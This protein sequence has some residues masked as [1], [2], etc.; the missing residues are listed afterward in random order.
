MRSKIMKHLKPEQD[1]LVQSRDF[2]TEKAESET[3]ELKCLAQL[4][5]KKE[6]QLPTRELF[7]K[8]TN[9]LS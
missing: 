8:V 5:T 3:Y 4:L 2:E 9:I 1:Y 6:K 7:N